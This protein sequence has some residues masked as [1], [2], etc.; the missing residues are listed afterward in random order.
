MAVGVRIGDAT[1]DC[2]HEGILAV[3]LVVI[4][5]HRSAVPDVGLS[6]RSGALKLAVGVDETN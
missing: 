1:V 6:K 2:W 5:A 4:E 3:Q